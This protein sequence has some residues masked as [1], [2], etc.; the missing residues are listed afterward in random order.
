[1]WLA[2]LTFVGITAFFLLTRPPAN[3]GAQVAAQIPANVAASTRLPLVGV[4]L[5]TGLGASPTDVVGTAVSEGGGP[6]KVLVCVTAVVGDVADSA[7]ENTDGR[8]IESDRQGRFVLSCPTSLRYLASVSAEGHDPVARLI[9]CE[10][11]VEDELIFTLPKNHTSAVVSGIVEDLLG[12]PVPT[13]TVS[14]KQHPSALPI[15]VGTNDSGRFRIPCPLGAIE[16]SVSARGYARAV[17]DVMSP[18]HSQD[19]VLV[20]GVAL[21]GKVQD[22]NGVPLS[23]LTVTAARQ[24]ERPGGVETTSDGGFHFANLAPGQYVVQAYGQRSISSRYPVAIV[25]F[26]QPDDLL[27]VATSGAELHGAI[28]VEGEPCADGAL[29]VAGSAFRSERTSPDGRVVIGGVA[30]G[31]N[32]LTASCEGGVRTVDVL[33][34]TPSSVIRREWHLRASATVRGEVTTFSG[35]AVPGAQVVLI[36]PE[37][38]AVATS[39]VS[40][41][42]GRFSCTGATPKTYDCRASLRTGVLSNKVS[43]LVDEAE[44]QKPPFVVLKLPPVGA[45]HASVISKDRG[46]LSN[47]RVVVYGGPGIPVEAVRRFDDV[48]VAENLK[49][50]SYKVTL[51][52]AGGV[53]TSSEVQAVL[54]DDGD[55]TRVTIAGPEPVLISGT[56]LDRNGSVVPDAWIEAEAAVPDEIVGLLGKSLPA[57]ALTGQ[58]GSFR[59]ELLA[60][61]SIQLR[62]TSSVGSAAAEMVA[63]AR[64]V[65][66]RL[67]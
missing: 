23:G 63:P 19:F 62:V 24:D 65:E 7:S 46:S 18:S 43:V 1:M 5:R 2:G 54:R 58:D 41:V 36:D 35:T 52:G 60:P 45:V 20:P 8:C 64:G 25:P 14:C 31:A 40:D 44:P 53:G 4:Q 57:T 61:R 16:L 15:L 51:I 21:S 34:I 10:R 29:S 48:F 28:F 37:R 3:R 38:G 49:P 9:D 59:I 66:V 26:S 50:G 6:L 56:V 27:I 42:N 12:G 22:G 13:A 33:D 55:V 11:D 47:L 67:N 39:C 32:T 30:P 17:R